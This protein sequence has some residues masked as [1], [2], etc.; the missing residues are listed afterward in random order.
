MAS[1]QKNLLE[2]ILSELGTMKKKLPNG[3]LKRM[4]QNFQEMKDFQHELK[5]DFSDIKYTLLNPENGVIVRV[6]K[7]TAFRRDSETT[8]EEL[9]ELKLELS[10]LQDWKSGVVKALWVL[11]S[12]LIGVLGWIFSEA[13][14]KF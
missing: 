13:M 5:E 8:P 6:N 9:L 7:N 10:K 2:N 4:E 1:T 11:F 14:S 12:G 3:E